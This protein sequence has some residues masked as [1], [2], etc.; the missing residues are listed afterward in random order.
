MTNIVI[1]LRFKSQ[2][3]KQPFYDKVNNNNNNS[4]N[5]QSVIEY[6]ST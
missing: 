2:G 5:K 1:C 6:N 3:H 4:K